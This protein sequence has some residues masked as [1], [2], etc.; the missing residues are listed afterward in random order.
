MKYYGLLRLQA[1]ALRVTKIW[2][3]QDQMEETNNN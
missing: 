1:L 2:P 3:G